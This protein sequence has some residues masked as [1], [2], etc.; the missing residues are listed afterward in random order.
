MICLGF[1][2][3][4]F[5]IV[6]CRKC[7]VLFRNFSVLTVNNRK[8]NNEDNEDSYDDLQDKTQNWVSLDIFQD[9]TTLL[10]ALLA[11]IGTAFEKVYSCKRILLV[12][13]LGR[14]SKVENAMLIWFAS[15]MNISDAVFVAETL[16]NN[17]LLYCADRA[18]HTRFPDEVE[19]ALFFTL[20]VFICDH[21]WEIFY[22]VFAIRV[23]ALILDSGLVVLAWIV[24]TLVAFIINHLIAAMVLVLV[25]F[26]FKDV[27]T[28]V[29]KHSEVVKSTLTV[30]KSHRVDISWF[31]G[32]RVQ[33]RVAIFILKRELLLVFVEFRD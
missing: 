23:V 10:I 22:V 11:H 29:F 14:G 15:D 1:V 24:E 3:V 8:A 17:Y 25:G 20:I 9:I 27:A 7:K 19:G 18:S 32:V 16:F 33:V 2:K 6:D 26:H 30:H 28:K 31:G 4:S 12:A 13:N 5:A 21:L